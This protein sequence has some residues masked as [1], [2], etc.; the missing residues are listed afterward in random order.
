MEEFSFC[1]ASRLL[2]KQA[3]RLECESE[4]PISRCNVSPFPMVTRGITPL[5]VLP[6]L[7]PLL[8]TA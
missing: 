1:V 2:R 4:V 3:C 8:V 7:V 5:A 6:V